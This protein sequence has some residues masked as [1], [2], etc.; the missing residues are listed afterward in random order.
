MHY[1]ENPLD[2]LRYYPLIDDTGNFVEIAEVEPLAEVLRENDK[3][4]TRKLKIG[5]KLSFKNYVKASVDFI[6]EKCNTDASSGYGAQLASSGDDAQLASS[7]DDAQLASS[8]YG[9]QLASSGDGAKLASSGYG[10]Q[11][12]SSGYGAKL[13]S[14]GD[15]AKLASSGDGAKLASSG[16][17]AMLASSGDWA[18]VAGIGINNKAK[19][20][21]GNW[22]VLAE[23][24]YGK[25]VCVKAEKVDGEIIKA[26]TWY[27][28]QNGVFTEA[29]DND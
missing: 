28:L 25:P 26:D 19:G 21:K 9:A 23:W 11:L 3:C 20:A 2:V 12:A 4:A 10:A 22:I 17:G 6:F 5:A 24:T 29:P 1:C 16:Y 7:G 15:G 14:S 18:I 13:A 27:M 8:G